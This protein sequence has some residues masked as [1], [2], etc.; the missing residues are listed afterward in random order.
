MQSSSHLTVR[1]TEVLFLFSETHAGTSSAKEV[2]EF[3]FIE[4]INFMYSE[5]FICRHVQ[6]KKTKKI[7]PNHKKKKGNKERKIKESRKDQYNYQDATKGSFKRCS[8]LV[9]AITMRQTYNRIP[10]NSCKSIFMQTNHLMQPS[11]S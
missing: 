11:D 8:Q 2:H 1:S 7:I 10:W 3:G 4:E 9:C 6:K 5:G